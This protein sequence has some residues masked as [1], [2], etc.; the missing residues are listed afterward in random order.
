MLVGFDSPSAQSALM[1]YILCKHWLAYSVAFSR[2]F[3]SYVLKKII[4][5]KM[6]TI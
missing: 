6:S 4:L 2:V 1:C 3:S 5:D